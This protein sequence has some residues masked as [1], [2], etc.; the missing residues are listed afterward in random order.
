MPAL[1]EETVF[2]VLLLPHPMEPVLNIK[3]WLLSLISWFGF[4]AYHLH[5]FTPLFFREPAFLVGAGSIGII[6]TISYLKSGSA[7]VPI[8]LHWLIVVVWLLLFGGLE[9]FQ[10]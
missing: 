6:C 2:R 5:P 1:L 9:K 8:T 3:R 7:W 4:M 10:T